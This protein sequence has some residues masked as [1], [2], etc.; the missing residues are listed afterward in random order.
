ML[1]R[2]FYKPK[3]KTS[4]GYHKF[5]FSVCDLV[6]STKPGRDFM[7]FRT[8]VLIKTLCRKRELRT[9]WLSDRH[10]SV[11]ITSLNTYQPVL[12]TFLYLHI[13]TKFG[14]EDLPVTSM[15]TY[16]PRKHQPKA[17]SILLT[18][19]KDVHTPQ[20]DNMVLLLRNFNL[21]NIRKRLVIFTPHSR[22]KVR[23]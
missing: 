12:F 14:T 7:K 1:C 11:L 6:S 23:I 21:R 3:Q 18:C 8:G 16:S 9:N 19:D 22:G 10:T 20:S 15:N 5:P 17:Y 4:C 13:G 2:V